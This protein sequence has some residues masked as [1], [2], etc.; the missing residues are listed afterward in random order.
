MNGLPLHPMLSRPLPPPLWSP[1]SPMARPPILTPEPLP[2]VLPQAFALPAVVSTS[3]M[4]QHAEA[5]DAFAPADA[6]PILPDDSPLVRSVGVS[7]HPTAKSIQALQEGFPEARARLAESS[8]NPFNRVVDNAGTTL[9]GLHKLGYW[10]QEAIQDHQLGMLDDQTKRLGSLIIAVVATLGLKQGVLGVGEFLG[11]GSWYG[12]MAVTPKVVNAMVYLKTGVNLNQLYTTNE[13]QR[14]SLYRDPGYL[15]L[16]LLP[17]SDINRAARRLGIRENAPDKRQQVEDRIRRI[18]IQSNT[19]WMLVAGPAT[20]VISGLFCDQLQD[21][22]TRG[23]N[24]LRKW[25]HGHRM[26]GAEGRKMIDRS[27]RYL[28]QVTG[29]VVESDLST[30]WRGFG[31]EASNK[32]GLTKHFRIDEATKAPMEQ[33]LEGILQYMGEQKPDSPAMAEADTWLEGQTEK[34]GGL[35]RILDETHGKVLEAIPHRAEADEVL[36]LSGGKLAKALESLTGSPEDEKIAALLKTAGGRESAETALKD[37]YDAKALYRAHDLNMISAEMTVHNMKRAVAEARTGK[38][39]AGRLRHLVEQIRLPVMQEYL[40]GQ[41]NI[42]RELFPAD[43]PELFKRFRDYAVNKQFGPAGKLVGASPDAMLLSGLKNRM[44]RTLWRRRVGWA[45]AGLLGATA[46][47]TLFF[48]GRQFK[49]QP[50]VVH[51]S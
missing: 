32:L 33:V 17:E 45:G 9:D 40:T 30:W 11:F 50:K 24:G 42:V 15:P 25:W 46:L 38:A 47:Y 28:R 48:V 51:R 14:V 5:S 4:P 34:L 6:T 44:L 19:W 43:K 3:R 7:E 16:H 22:V 10:N 39:S 26:G 1:A 41:Q 2:F 29:E 20:P 21:P 49:D 13:G 31:A 35:R 8:W 12:A 37:L 18:A 36:K 23:I 27:E